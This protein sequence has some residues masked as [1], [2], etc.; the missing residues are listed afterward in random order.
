MDIGEITGL[1]D[2]SKLPKNVQLGANCFWSDLKHL[3]GFAAAAV[4]V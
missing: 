3:V 2:Y 1:W 4:P